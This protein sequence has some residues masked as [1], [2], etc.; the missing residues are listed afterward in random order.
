MYRDYNDNELLYLIGESNESALDIMYDKYK[1]I[2]EI[3]AKKYRLLG[4][5]VG[6]EYN[7]LIQE[8]MLG[9]SDA[10]KSYK[11]N[12]DTKFSSFANVCIERQ[13][14][15]I[16]SYSSRKK[17]SFL[18]DSY[19]LDDSIDDEG[20]TLLDFLFSDNLDPSVAI[21]KEETKEELFDKIYKEL[22][23]FEKSV[24][25]LKM[26]GLDYKEISLLLEKS[27]KSVDSAL[28]RIRYKV[29]KILDSSENIVD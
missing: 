6:L 18:N 17:H 22:S 14:L 21:E 28:Q 15:S 12:K 29:K 16:L 3:K 1:P 27:Y 9:L 20:R 8:G 25:D 24:L 7:D 13:I 2:V 23:N 4:K 10:I 5:K 11:D 19:S 26:V